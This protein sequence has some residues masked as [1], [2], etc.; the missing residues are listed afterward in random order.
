MRVRRRA[1][2]HA[3][4]E[5]CLAK[6]KEWCEKSKEKR[7]KQIDV[8]RERPE[9][10][11]RRHERIKK[12]YLENREERLRINKE[13][14]EKNR[15]YRAEYHKAYRAKNKSII[16][17][18]HAAHRRDNPN[19]RIASRLRTRIWVAI[20]KAGT[21]KRSTTVVLVG[22]SFEF[23]LSHL[24]ARFKEGMTWENYGQWE[25]DHIK[26]CDSFDLTDEEQQRKCFHFS[27]LQ[28]LWMRENRSKS[29]IVC[30]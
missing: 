22:C 12:D 20:R 5:L 16:Y 14:R 28:P 25:V 7:K 6:N 2:Y 8:W 26:P 24:E 18:K 21:I 1:Y 10:K 27:N 17:A 23:L 11:K 4:K 15:E 13:W 30:A 19:A 3:N 29:W 9:V